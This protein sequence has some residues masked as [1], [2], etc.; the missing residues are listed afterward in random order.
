[1]ETDVTSWLTP[2]NLFS[3]SATGRIILNNRTTGFYPVVSP[4]AGTEY[5]MSELIKAAVSIKDP[6][7]LFAFLALLLLI[8]F[9]TKRVPEALF[10]LAGEKMTRER[11]SQL[12]RR[13]FLYVFLAFLALCG[14]AVLG[15]VLGYMT[16][17]KAATVDELKQE[18]ALRHAD[19]GAS[20]QAMEEY[21]RGLAQAE[22]QKLSEAI[23][24]LESS[25]KAVPT[26]AAQETLALLY[27]KAGDSRRAVELAGQAVST[28]RQGG[29]AV[30]TAKAERVLSAVS[31]SASAPVSVSKSCPSGAA[32]IGPKLDLPPG[33]ES[34]EAATSLVPCVYKGIL[35]TQSEQWQYYKLSVPR[36]R[37]LQVV[38]R[39]R[40]ADSV[41]TDIRL[42]G[43]DGGALGGYTAFGDSSVTKPLEYKAD[44]P[45]VVFVSVS[46]GVRGSAFDISIR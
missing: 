45:A 20:R 7:T 38:M 10:R 17:A 34:F 2:R 19:D 5:R 11:F 1:M 27:Q 23:A 44:D 21:Q 42:H 16:T 32:L 39:T 26:A 36:G 6:F 15:Q 43:P 25:L 9:R 24:S 4:C 13:A 28:A 41:S 35:D 14:L 8:A 31:G 30:R 3:S 46:G 29:D 37:T 12:M 33:G 18:L 40:D 22:D